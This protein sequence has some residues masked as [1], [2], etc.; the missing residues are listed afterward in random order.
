MIYILIFVLDGIVAG[1]IGAIIGNVVRGQSSPGFWWSFF[2]GP[3]GWI[4]VLLYE[5]LRPKCPDCR[6]VIVEGA[7]RCKN[8]GVELIYEDPT[9]TIAPPIYPRVR[10]PIPKAHRPIPRVRSACLF[11][12][13]LA[14]AAMAQTNAP[15]PAEWQSIISGTELK[16]ECLSK[17]PTNPAFMGC[18][19]KLDISVKVKNNQSI[20]AVY[21]LDVSFLDRGKKGLQLQESFQRRDNQSAQI[22]LLS[23]TSTNLNFHASLEHGK[24][25]DVYSVS[26]FGYIVRLSAYG[27]P[28]KILA[29][30]PAL[31]R[32][33]KDPEKMQLLE[34][35]KTVPLK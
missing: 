23:G 35:G 18:Y 33:A 19:P 11:A 20:P 29:S 34:S 32:L 3:I 16:V 17:K 31:D 6:G 12:L 1:I 21:N 5:D 15:T 22:S 24:E 7:A 10:R 27:K 26:W 14:G 30:S 4:I 25:E 9:L 8:C 13:I 28:L 2:L